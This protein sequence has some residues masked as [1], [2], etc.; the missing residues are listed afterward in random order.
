MPVKVAAG[1]GN[2]GGSTRTEAPP[3]TEFGWEPVD[4]G[5]I[6]ASHYLEATCLVWVLNAMKN[7]AWN[8]A[9]KLVPT[10]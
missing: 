6:D 4:V 10:A 8:R 5:G 3:A 7:G 9:F 2:T 1:W